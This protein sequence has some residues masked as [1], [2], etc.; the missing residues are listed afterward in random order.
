M[1]WGDEKRKPD[2]VLMS[3]ME[4]SRKKN[5]LVFFEPLPKTLHL[6]RFS[7]LK[8]GRNRVK[9]DGIQL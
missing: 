3:K 2:E 5:D 7:N 9:W 1:D 4:I 6:D 8:Q